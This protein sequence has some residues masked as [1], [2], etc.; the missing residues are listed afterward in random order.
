MTW[1]FEVFVVTE[2]FGAVWLLGLNVD[3]QRI[4]NLEFSDDER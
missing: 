2:G 1:R 4:G 3:F